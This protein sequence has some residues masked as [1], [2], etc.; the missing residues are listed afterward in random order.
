MHYGKPSKKPRAISSFSFG[1]KVGKARLILPLPHGRWF[2]SAKP[3]SSWDEIR[4]YLL[5][6]DKKEISQK[7]KP[8]A[9]IEVRFI[10]FIII[11]LLFRFNFEV[12]ILIIEVTMLI[13]EIIVV[14]HC[15]ELVL[16]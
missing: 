2:K 13:I 10:I 7:R 3:D 14:S 8:P 16:K 4:Q 9:S 1:I 11:S 5:V 15:I 12:T 6:A